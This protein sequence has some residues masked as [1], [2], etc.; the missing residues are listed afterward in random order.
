MYELLVVDDEVNSRN[1]LCTCFPW[2]DIGFHVCGQ[3]DNGKEALA[4]MNQHAV[5]VVFTDV[6][7]PVMSGI[8][9]AQT[10]SNMKGVKPTV[11][12]L[13]AHDDFKYAQEALRYNVR[14]YILKPSNFNELR[15]SFEIIRTELDNKYNV[16]AS[17]DFSASGDDTMKKVLEYCESNYREGTLA[18][19]AD[20]LYL[21][22]SYLSSLIKQKTSLNFSDHIQ[23]A[24]MKQAAL[25]LRDP[26]V[27]I[28]NISDM[29]GYLNPNNFARAFKL[30]Y[31]MSPSEYRM[32]KLSEHEE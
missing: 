27:K 16:R 25:L 4:F 7:M 21:N 29:V 5:H 11:V 23:N 10:I 31:G 6:S 17:A 18:E 20:Q 1:T 2:E 15:S 24:R 26:N 12:F 32:C 19:I 9:L 14:Y 30:Y 3:A 13:S 22:T 28:Y 8:E